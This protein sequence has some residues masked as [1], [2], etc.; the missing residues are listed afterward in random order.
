MIITRV[1]HNPKLKN[2]GIKVIIV[3]VIVVVIV[4]ITII[5]III[6]M[7][8][9]IIIIIIRTKNDFKNKDKPLDPR[10]YI[11]HTLQTRNSIHGPSHPGCVRGIRSA[12]H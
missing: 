7:I 1:S 11:Y 6:I 2:P 5:I 10:F 3:I 12:Q 4:T 9:I 8:I